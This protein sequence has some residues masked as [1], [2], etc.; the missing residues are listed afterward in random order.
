VK[1]SRERGSAVWRGGATEIL[2]YPMG[3]GNNGMGLET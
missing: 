3:I 2:R 1:P